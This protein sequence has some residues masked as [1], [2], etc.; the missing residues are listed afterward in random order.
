MLPS[1]T[2]AFVMIFFCAL[3]QRTLARD[4]DESG[5]GEGEQLG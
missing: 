2:P 1:V 4:F 3:G 5:P